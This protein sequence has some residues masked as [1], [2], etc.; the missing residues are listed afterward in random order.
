MFLFQLKKKRDVSQHCRRQGEATSIELQTGYLIW[1]GKE[2]TDKNMVILGYC[3]CVF[4]EGVFGIFVL[5]S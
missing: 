5:L 4:R 2:I 1:N 3:L